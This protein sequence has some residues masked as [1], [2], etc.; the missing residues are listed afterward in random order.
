[1]PDVPHIPVGLA[2][3]A[4]TAH[5]LLFSTIGVIGFRRRAVS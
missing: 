2:A 4:L 5:A 1:V 3:L